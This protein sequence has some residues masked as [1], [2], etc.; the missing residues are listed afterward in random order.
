M[1]F[2]DEHLI[3][4]GILLDFGDHNLVEEV[5]LPELLIV[6]AFLIILGIN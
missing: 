4:V 5:D 2:L 1:N 6:A 3:A